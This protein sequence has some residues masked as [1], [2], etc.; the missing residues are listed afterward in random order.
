MEFS[1][2]IEK[3]FKKKIFSIICENSII[4]KEKNILLMI[5]IQCKNIIKIIIIFYNNKKYKYTYYDFAEFFLRKISLLLMYP[6]IFFIIIKFK[7]IIS[8]QKY[9]FLSLYVYGFFMLKIK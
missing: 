3:K 2:I 7:W 5:F 9:V 6:V 8:I 1:Q 4:F